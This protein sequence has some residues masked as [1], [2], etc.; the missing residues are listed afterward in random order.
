MSLLL[1]TLAILVGLVLVRRVVRGSSE[2]AAASWTVV[3]LF[4]GTGLLDALTLEADPIPGAMGFVLA[5]VALA[6]WRPVRSEPSPARAFVGDLIALVA[7]AIPGIHGHFVLPQPWRLEERLFGS[8]R[9]LLFESPF[10][11]TGIVGLVIWAR[12][13]WRAVARP[14][15]VVASVVLASI[16]VQR[17]MADAPFH[18]ALPA[19]A[20]GTGAFLSW[21][22]RVVANNPGLPLVAAGVVLTVWNG[23]FMEQY[24]SNRIPR[25]LPVAFSQVTETNAEILARAVGSPP[26]W[27]ANWLFGLRHHVTPA[28][29]DVVV[30]RGLLTTA[31]TGTF[32]VDDPQVDPSLLAEGW[33]AK[34]S[35]EGVGYRGLAGSARLLLPLDDPRAS[36]FWIR[37]AG[38]GDLSVEINSAAV[39]IVKLDSGF[40]VHAFEGASGLWRAGVNEVRLT[41]LGAGEARI[42]GFGFGAGGRP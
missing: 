18:A 17:S 29:F 40:G 36:T 24:R 37:A 16:A 30:G 6:L 27:P 13:D 42:A 20:L 21:L 28:K 41:H 26:A 11:W 35:W 31:A 25:D 32:P 23:L 33:G 34:R 15:I 9:G 39:A 38:S 3:G 4:L 14:V 19:L 22:L 1:A 2:S 8:P 12:R 10:L 5:S 7:V